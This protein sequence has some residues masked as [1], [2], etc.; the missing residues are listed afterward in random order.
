M[1]SVRSVGERH[2][3]SSIS[4]SLV[5]NLKRR[6]AGVARVDLVLRA[7]EQQLERQRESAVAREEAAFIPGPIAHQNMLGEGQV[8]WAQTG[9]CWVGGAMAKGFKR[10]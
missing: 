2:T 6:C 10:F 9:A 5:G 7:H 3:K 4:L 1:L 8:A